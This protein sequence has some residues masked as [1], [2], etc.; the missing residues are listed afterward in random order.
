MKT[1]ER[2]VKGN[3]LASISRTLAAFAVERDWEQFHSPKNLAMALAVEAAELL[4]HF[5]WLTERES[6]H[7]DSEKVREIEEEAADIQI[8]LLMIADKLGIDLIRAVEA[9]IEKNRA[10]YPAEQVRG[11]A[12]KPRDTGSE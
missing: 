3:D 6:S 8:Y 5:Q 4:E 2:R 11:S 7:L 12:A 10:K 9:K 1:D